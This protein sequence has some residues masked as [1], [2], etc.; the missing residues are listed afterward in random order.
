MFTE[1]KAASDAG[2]V[3]FAWEL[4]GLGLASSIHRGCCR[5]R[6]AAFEKITLLLVCYTALTHP[7]RSAR[8][9]ALLQADCTQLLTE[10]LIP[11]LLYQGSIAQ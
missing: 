5:A 10:V 7:T 9:Q 2:C 1:D 8:A 11:N 3:Q 4:G 6:R